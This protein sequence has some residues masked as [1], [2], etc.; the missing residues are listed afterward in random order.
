MIAQY[1]VF[2]QNT[3]LVL[4]QMIE[5]ALSGLSEYRLQATRKGEK[6]REK[7]RVFFWMLVALV[8]DEWTANLTQSR[9][10]KEPET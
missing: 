6:K 9:I 3:I 7:R 10:S 8:V 4:F 1:L 5:K 2:L